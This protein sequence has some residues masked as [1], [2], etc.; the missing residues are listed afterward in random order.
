MVHDKTD[1]VKV[2]LTISA[3]N[4]DLST[5]AKANTK[6]D[7]GQIL[8]AADGSGSKSHLSYSSEKCCINDNHHILRNESCNNGKRYLPDFFI[9]DFQDAKFLFN[10]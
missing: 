10:M 7:H 1:L 2:F 4:H 9:G 6:H 8:Q 5:S 3:S